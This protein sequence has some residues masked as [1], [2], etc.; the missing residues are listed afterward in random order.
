MILGMEDYSIGIGKE[1]GAILFFSD[2]ENNVI[3]IFI[4]INKYYDFFF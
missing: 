4:D 3:Y 2:L 1:L